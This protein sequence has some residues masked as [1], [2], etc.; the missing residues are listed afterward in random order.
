M[1]KFVSNSGANKNTCRKDVS[2]DPDD[3]DYVFQEDSSISSTTD[4]SSIASSSK[5]IVS[6]PNSSPHQRQQNINE[7]FKQISSMAVGGTQHKCITDAIAYF[8]CK[9]NKAFS[10]KGFRNMVNKLNICIKSLAGIL[11]KH[12]LTIRII[13]VIE[14]NESHTAN[15]ISQEMLKCLSEWDIPKDKIMAVVSDNGANITRAVKD[16][17][18]IKDGAVKKLI[19]DVS[20]RWNS[21]F[22]ML[23]RFVE[24]SKIISEIMLTRP[25]GPEMISARQLQE[26]YDVIVVLRPLEMVTTEMSAENYV[27][28]SKVLPIVSCLNNG[29]SS[30]P[31]KSDLC[32]S[33]K[34]AVI[35][36]LNKQ[37]GNIE[38]F[39]L[40]P[41]ATLLDPRFKNL[42]F[43]NPVACANAINH[44]KEMVSNNRMILSSSSSEE[45][46]SESAKEFNLWEY[47][48]GLAHKR[49]NSRAS[50][51]RK[52][53]SNSPSDQL[54]MNYLSTP[55]SPLKQNPLETWEDMKSVY[56]LIYME[57]QKVFCVVATSVPSERLFSKAGATLSKERNRLLG[58]RL[59]KL[60]FLGSIDDCYWLVNV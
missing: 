5:T 45:D 40:C 28:I 27:T 26:I 29:V 35:A 17:F 57:A 43:K 42:H 53:N 6:I 9:D 24:L 54:V 39:N 52:T 33:L 38:I 58:K 19:L 30:Q 21:V 16:S 56:P 3:P 41:V 60:L 44:F 12:I 13:G 1:S 50:S 8:L 14:L 36:Q 7:V 15:Y 48:Q 37:F 2:N 51:S 11:L 31:P 22:Y 23:Q 46:T 20:T 25:N 47:Y 4:I 18:G 34:N 55:V 32:E 10:T 49:S 59:F